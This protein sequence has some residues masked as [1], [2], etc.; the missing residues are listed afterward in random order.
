MTLLVILEILSVILVQ[1][2][3]ILQN[4]SI[5]LKI[6]STILSNN[7]RGLAG[8]E[9][10]SRLGQEALGGCMACARAR[11]GGS[12]MRACGRGHVDGGLGGWS[13]GWTGG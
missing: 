2:S 4:F 3:S 6:P 12:I 7:Y 1:C 9:G 11:G 8:A 5:V 13:V 10:A